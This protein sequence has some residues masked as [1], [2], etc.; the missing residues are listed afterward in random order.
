MI[1][2]GYSTYITHTSPLVS[3]GENSYMIMMQVICDAVYY[4]RIVLTD[5]VSEKSDFIEVI[6][7][8]KDDVY[9]Y[10]DKT[11]ELFP[12]F[13]KRVLFF[14]KEYPAEYESE[15]INKWLNEV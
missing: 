4:V 12:E 15:I 6:L 13:E 7:E 3:D 11:L 8:S 5:P 10:I 14:D 1:L 9:K 2:N